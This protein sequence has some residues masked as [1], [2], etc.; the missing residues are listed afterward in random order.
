[1][2]DLPER[3][4][5]PFACVRCGMTIHSEQRYVYCSDACR[6]ADVPTEPV[7]GGVRS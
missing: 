4:R 3:P 5:E 6:D 2:I 7:C 1:M